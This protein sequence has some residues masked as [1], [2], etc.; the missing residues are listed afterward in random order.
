MSDDITRISYTCTGGET[1]FPYPFTIFEPADLQVF[2][3]RDNESV[4][5][6]LDIDYT[7]TNDTGPGN[8]LPIFT[9]LPGDIVILNLAIPIERTIDYQNGNALNGDT[10]NEDF[11]KIYGILRQ[12]NTFSNALSPHYANDSNPQDPGDIILPILGANEY[13]AKGPSGNGIIAASTIPDPAASA[14]AAELLSSDPT[15][16]CYI[17]NTSK[18]VRVQT[19]LQ[20]INNRTTVS[21]GYAI[22]LNDYGKI[23]SFATNGES[24]TL[25]QISSVPTGWWV[26]IAYSPIDEQGY[27]TVNGNGSDTI[28]IYLGFKLIGAN[29]KFT[30]VNNGTNWDVIDN[31]YSEV[32]RLED[33]AYLK[34]AG[35]YLLC[36]GSAVSRTL[37]N[38]LFA[39]L[40]TT[41]GTGDGSTTFN[42][43]DARGRSPLGAGIGSGLTLRIIGQTG[44]EETHILIAAEIPDLNPTEGF[45]TDQPGTDVY[46]GGGTPKK[47]KVS[48]I[49]AGGGGAHN[50]MHPFY[51]N[52]PM[53]KAF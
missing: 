7:I 12:V 40:G 9:V 18:N 11:D 43:P 4:L 29:R 45:V 30:F 33:F 31:D 6:S 51:V 34:G 32:G 26:Q 39:K 19:F 10:L 24:V 16:G 36:D 38:V 44:G 35:E 47:T 14:L 8:V 17:V 49:N 20:N 27:I 41:W 2:R 22:Q 1:A 46:Q 5:L 13:W 23:L 15:L 3:I 48:L 42:L 21:S 52:Y 37:Y 25:P 53:I 28:L 50:T